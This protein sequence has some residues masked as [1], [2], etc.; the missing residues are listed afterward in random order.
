MKF[1]RT[2]ANMSERRL[3]A[4]LV[5]DIFRPPIRITT[6][7]WGRKY[8]TFTGKQSTISVGEFNPLA[9]PYMEYVYDCLDNPYIPYIV[10]K[11]SAR[12]GWTTVINI[13]RGKRIHTDPTN[14]L[15]GFATGV[16]VRKFAT[17]QWRDFLAGAPVLK[18]IINVGVAKNKENMYQY[19]FA[20]G[21]L[22][23]S[24]LGSIGNQKGDN[25][26]Y[27]EIEEP[28]DVPDD[29]ANQGDSFK[30][31]KQRMKLVPLTQRKF[32]FGGTG[33]IKDFSRVEKAIK[34]SNYMVF[35][36]CCHVCEQLVPMDETAF[37]NIVWSEY[38]N[39]YIDSIYG[40]DD[41]TTAEFLCP[42]CK[43]NWTF[44]QK[45]LNIIKGKE[46]G[47][48]DHTGNFSKGWHQKNPRVTDTFGFDFSELMSCFE[49]GSNYES[50][51]QDYILAKLE[52]GKGNEAPMMS[53]V[54]NR[55]GGTYAGGFSAMEEEEMIA[56][57]S[58]YPEGIAPYEALIPFVGIDVQHNRFA[59]V[60]FAAGRNGNLYLIK[61]V[62]LFGN[63]FNWEDPVWQRLTDFVLGGVTHVTGIPLP[64]MSGGIDSGDG[65]TAELV[66]RWV[67]LMNESYGVDIRAT[68]GAKELKYSSDEIYREPSNAVVTTLHNTKRTLAQTMGVPVYYI[69]T[70]RCHD[71][72]LRRISL[73]KNKDNYGNVVAHHDV[74]YF[75]EQSYGD[76]EKQMTSCR[77]VISTTSSIVKEV[78]KLVPG[79]HMDAMA[80]TK[81]AFFAYYAAEVRLFTNEHWLEIEK[82]VYHDRAA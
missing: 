61:W 36:A 73:N 49:D 24:T 9:M 54:N 16:A 23:L 47:F 10:S 1:K 72:V 75:N 53:F 66:Y 17:G 38:P 5:R 56:L 45:T 78:Y 32:I 70:H 28:D 82:G 4:T 80:A 50:L 69:G 59:V 81:N 37:D 34:E 22:N 31:L 26:P 41:P 55:K 63:V 76:Y 19:S 60:S 27:V 62:E 39:R 71:E 33:T 14:M 52:L 30:N 67:K 3:L 35:K 12:I 46:F 18:K 57:R 44:E 8:V 13:Y 48:T 29:V 40:K 11:K 20:G 15:L 51:A 58:N 42:Y 68:K 6:M 74:F 25:I 64:F 21:Q 43:S 79:K 7:D 65:K 2:L 77:K